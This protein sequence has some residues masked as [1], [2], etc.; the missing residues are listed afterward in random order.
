MS[1]AVS[2]DLPV[3]RTIEWNALGEISR[4]Q[5]SSNAAIAAPYYLR[6]A[7]MENLAAH[8]LVEHFP[9]LGTASR[10]AWLITE[11]GRQKA[12]VRDVTFRG[13]FTP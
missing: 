2:S 10:P 1:E 12:L 8:G 3:L 13:R 5:P 9:G 6:R 4:R 11:K 7:A